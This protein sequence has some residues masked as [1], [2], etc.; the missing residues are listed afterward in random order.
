MLSLKN[1]GEWWKGTI[2]TLLLHPPP[3]LDAFQFSRFLCQLTPVGYA[4]GKPSGSIRAGGR[5]KPGYFP[6]LSVPQGISL[7]MSQVMSSL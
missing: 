6:Y 2:S 4:L 3:L 1:H 7:E 5:G